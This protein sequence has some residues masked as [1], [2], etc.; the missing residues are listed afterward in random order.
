MILDDQLDRMLREATPALQTPGYLRAQRALKSSDNN[1]FDGFFT[2]CKAQHD[3]VYLVI[4]V[5]GLDL[6]DSSESTNPLGERLVQVQ[7]N[8]ELVRGS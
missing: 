7:W 6:I 4:Q 5:A 1:A 2:D 3:G 8:L